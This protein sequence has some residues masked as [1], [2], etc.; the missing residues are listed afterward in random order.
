MTRRRVVALVAAASTLVAAAVTGWLLPQRA[1]P[2]DGLHLQVW[3]HEREAVAYQ[4][5]VVAGETFQ[6]RHTHSV[7]RRPVVET[8]SITG[9]AG[10]GLEELWFDEFG[11]NLPAGPE[12][13][14]SVTT[15]FHRESD[16]FRVEHH[17][18]L[19]PTVPL[20][21]GSASVD[22]VLTF[23]DGADLR[24]LE[25]ARAGAYVELRVTGG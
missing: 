13:I 4:R 16:G 11:P 10:I 1:D 18:R 2:I 15:T 14:G 24:L 12:Q 22:H 23:L 20:R 3:D 9:A 7:T 5:P 21:V 25:I 17:G 8:F 6:L 19:L